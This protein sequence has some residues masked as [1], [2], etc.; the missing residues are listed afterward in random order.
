MVFKLENTID[1]KRLE[2]YCVLRL[3]E[4]RP[5]GGQGTMDVELYLP[6]FCSFFSFLPTFYSFSSVTRVGLACI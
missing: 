1:L 4:L 2:S 6:T 5:P 3:I